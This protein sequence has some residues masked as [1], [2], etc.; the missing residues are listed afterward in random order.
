MQRLWESTKLQI[1]KYPEE[2]NS[3]G[4]NMHIS[5]AM[6]IEKIFTSIGLIDVASSRS[7]KFKDIQAINQRIYA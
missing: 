1:R 2:S 5:C 6:S 4:K 7:L 3:D